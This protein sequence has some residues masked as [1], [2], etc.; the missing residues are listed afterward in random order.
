M[1]ATKVHI[2]YV[3]GCCSLDARDSKA[4]QSNTGEI[5]MPFA[6]V[7]YFKMYYTISRTTCIEQGVSCFFFPTWCMHWQPPVL[8]RTQGLF[9]GR[10]CGELRWKMCIS[11]SWYLAFWLPPFCRLWLSADIGVPFATIGPTAG[12]SRWWSPRYNWRP[13][14]RCWTNSGTACA[15]AVR[16][17]CLHLWLQ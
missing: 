4:N 10:K 8:A 9:Y 5:S 3:G 7:K 1:G 16:R 13:S 11:G 6:I 15:G 14:W 12:A 2:W 17:T